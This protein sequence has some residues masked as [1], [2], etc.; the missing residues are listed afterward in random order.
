VEQARASADRGGARYRLVP[1]RVLVDP[2][3][4]LDGAEWDALRI[5]VRLAFI[6]FNSRDNRWVAFYP[7]PAGAAES[8]LSLDGFRAL[9]ARAIADAVLFEGYALYPYRPSAPKNHLRFQFGVLAPRAWSK[10]GSPGSRDAWWLQA[11]T[12]LAPRA[13]T[14][15]ILGRLRFLQLRRH[16]G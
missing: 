9:D 10:A 12:L 2:G 1:T 8:A 3:F 6:F 13:A 11:Q 14:G 4:V 7:S 15:R 16:E 5:P